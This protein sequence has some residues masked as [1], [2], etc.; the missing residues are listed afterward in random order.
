MRFERVKTICTKRDENTIKPADPVINSGTTIWT[1]HKKKNY[2]SDNDREK[3]LSN[4]RSDHEYIHLNNG[5]CSR[6]IRSK[7]FKSPKTNV[8]EKAI[9]QSPQAVSAERR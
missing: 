1:V 6:L 3:A 2:K 7:I 8:G 4:P 9:A 5:P